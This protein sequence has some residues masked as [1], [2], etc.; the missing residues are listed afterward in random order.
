MKK[1]IKNMVILL[2]IVFCISGTGL[3][4][5]TD[6]REIP[7]TR[8]VLMYQDPDPAEPGKILELRFKVTKHGS[9]PIENLTYKLETEHPFSIYP[10]HSKIKNVGWWRA[11][12]DKH[13]Y[14]LYYK[15]LVDENATEETH[16]IELLKRYNESQSWRSKEYDIRVGESEDTNLQLGSI[17]S[18]PKQLKSDTEDAE[19]DIEIQNI[20]NKNAENVK[21]ALEQIDGFEPSYTYSHE[22]M[23]GIIPFGESRTGTLYFDI[24]EDLPSGP[25]EGILTVNYK[26][27]GKNDYRERQF[28]VILQLKSRPEFELISAE[29]NQFSGGEK[30]EVRITVKNKGQKKAESVSVNSFKDITQPFEFKE[31]TDFI[32]TIEPGET[33]EA[34]IAFDIDREAVTKEHILEI[35]IRGIDGSDVIVEQK[36]IRINIEERES[37]EIPL[38][39]IIISALALILIV[40]GIYLLFRK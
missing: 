18:R 40:L 11:S 30:G 4:F 29:P 3:V 21:I 27:K 17:R 32:G 37:P 33:G 16:T 6:E 20:G 34:V 35:E 1:R 12:G 24:E 26:E 23:L 31:R 10:G 7:Y 36:Q 28:P 2:L 14:T 9:D 15:L 38:E 25:H 22:D 39:I 5:A 13:H 8:E 19:I